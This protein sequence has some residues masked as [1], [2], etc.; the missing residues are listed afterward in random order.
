M[1]VREVEQY[2]QAKQAEKEIIFLEKSSATVAL[3]AEAL[4]VEPERI[5]KT[6][7]FTLK[8]DRD[9]VVVACGTAKID[10]KKFKECFGCKAKMMSLEDTLLKTG[11][12]VGGVC[13]FGLPEGVEIYADV[14]LQQ[15]DFFYPAA[16]GTNTAVKMTPDELIEL[17]GAK[18]V[19]IC[20]E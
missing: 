16:G 2:F 7:A 1:G 18:W 12:P 8:D 15:F 13:P 11:H 9:L 20:K 19:D 10:N 3:A 5:A 4:G 6:L 17:T 14:S